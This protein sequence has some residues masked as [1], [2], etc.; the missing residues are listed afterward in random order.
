MRTKAE[1]DVLRKAVADGNV[2]I[3]PPCCREALDL[4]DEK[5]F[6]L[7]V[8][9]A[10]A[11][12]MAD[13]ARETM[14]AMS[15]QLGEK[16]ARIAKLEAALEKADELAGAAQAVCADTD[17]PR[18]GRYDSLLC[19]L[20]NR[21]DAYAEA[22]GWVPLCEYCGQPQKHLLHQP[23]PLGGVSYGVDDLSH[24]TTHC[25]QAR[26]ETRSTFTAGDDITTE[27]INPDTRK[28]YGRGI[29]TENSDAFQR[30][31]TRCTFSDGHRSGLLRD[32]PTVLLARA[33]TRKTTA[34]LR[35]KRTG[36][37]CGTD[38]W[39]ER[40]CVCAPCQRWLAETRKQTSEGH[41]RP[42]ST[43]P[44]TVEVESKAPVVGTDSRRAEA[45]SERGT[46]QTTD[47]TRK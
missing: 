12:L 47:E 37:P 44:G 45:P 34:T 29:V 41:G 38:T 31:I 17:R 7:A 9:S 16:Q 36:N 10:A 6:A 8:A 39:A 32:I 24:I 15:D 1:R 28:P 25:F 22:R 18:T 5:D 2:E 42:A 33:E 46:S 14:A 35:C 26:A 19:A 11:E 20:E 23:P 4:L 13:G 3:A 27:Y 43:L 40:P 21:W 30:G